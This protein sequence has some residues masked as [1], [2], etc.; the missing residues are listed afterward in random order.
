MLINHRR[1]AHDF[2]LRFFIVRIVFYSRHRQFITAQGLHQRRHAAKD[3]HEHRVF[4]FEDLILRQ[5]FNPQAPHGGDFP[6]IHRNQP[7]HGLQKST[8]A[9]AVHTDNPDLVSGIHAEIYTIKENFLPI[10]FGKIFYSYNHISNFLTVLFSV[11]ITQILSHKQKIFDSPH[12]IM[13]ED[14]WKGYCTLLEMLKNDCCI[15]TCNSHFF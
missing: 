9:R 5:I 14:M 7:G 12:G 8:L 4:R 6:G 13:V 1:M 11:S 3:F 15:N 10:A 2:L